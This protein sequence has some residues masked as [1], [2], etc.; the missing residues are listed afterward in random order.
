MEQTELERVMITKLPEHRRMLIE[1]SK[2]DIGLR[3]SS[4]T[5]YLD[6]VVGYDANMLREIDVLISRFHLGAVKKSINN[7]V[8]CKTQLQPSPSHAH[9]FISL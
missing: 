5:D 4:L 3:H 1:I 2:S 7:R 8:S 6:K 9:N